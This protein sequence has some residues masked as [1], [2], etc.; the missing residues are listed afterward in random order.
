M[1]KTIKITL[2]IIGILSILSGV[3]MYIYKDKTDAYYGLIIGIVIIGSLLL[4]KNKSEKNG[5]QK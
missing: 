4:T 2:L 3:F 1:N 5:S